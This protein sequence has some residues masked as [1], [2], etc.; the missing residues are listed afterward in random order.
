MIFNY[1]FQIAGNSDQTKSCPLSMGREK[2]LIQEN[3]LGL[4]SFVR[5]RLIVKVQKS[6]V[7]A[8]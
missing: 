8:F 3:L 2:D 7:F 4:G 6:Y 5:S 1:N